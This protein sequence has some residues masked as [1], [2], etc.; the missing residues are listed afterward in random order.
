M[1]DRFMAQTLTWARQRLNVPGRAF[2]SNDAVTGPKRT[3]V[4]MSASSLRILNDFQES[5]CRT[6]NP[7]T[8]TF[9]ATSDRIAA[10]VPA[11]PGNER[12]SN[13]TRTVPER[14]VQSKHAGKANGRDAGAYSPRRFET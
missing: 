8:L 11:P 6:C 5:T 9:I 7:I 3:D 10:T 12:H 4:C 13:G 2:K 1:C 14:S